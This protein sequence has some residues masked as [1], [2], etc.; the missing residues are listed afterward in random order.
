MNGSSVL[1]RE[2]HRDDAPALAALERAC[3]DYDV[4]SLR[5]FTWMLTKGRAHIELAELD[6]LVVAYALVLYKRATSLARLY[7]IAVHPSQ[8]GRGIARELLGRAECHAVEQDCVYLR[9]EVRPD[10]SGAIALY[11]R[12]GYHRFKI[13]HDYYEDHSD[14]LCFE[15]RL[16]HG[17]H[18]Q[19]LKVPYY[20]QTTGFTCGPACLMMALHALDERVSLTQRLELQ[21]WREATTIFMTAG[22]G[23]CGP[24]GLALA[25][26]RRG[27]R[28]QMYVNQDGDLFVDSVRSVQKKQV[29]RLVE[30]DFNEQLAAT[31]VE[32]DAR[33]PSV[34]ELVEA[35]RAGSVPVVLISSY[36]IAREKSPHWVVLTGFDDDFIYFHDPDLDREN[37]GRIPEKTYIPVRK[38]DFAK[39]ARFGRSQ[40]KAMLI[41]SPRSP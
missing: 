31:D 24:H 26:H 41:L 32:I 35:M 34:D 7:S 36:Q 33:P 17:E 3:F 25:A 4:I 30:E 37:Q 22:H 40:L 5:S 38:Q 21:L 2:A 10:N 29:I 1:Y 39:I 13:K 12:L 9:L 28:V 27:V 23:G 20:A 15:K 11:E 16:F 8:Q 18:A 19:R 6:G 14:A